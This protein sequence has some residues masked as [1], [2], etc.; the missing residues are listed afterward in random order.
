VCKL[1]SADTCLSRDGFAVCRFVQAS[2]CRLIGRRE[3]RRG[4]FTRRSV[5]SIIA[6]FRLEYAGLPGS[7]VGDIVSG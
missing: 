1:L 4:W 5:T 7:D 3:G 6:L 2:S